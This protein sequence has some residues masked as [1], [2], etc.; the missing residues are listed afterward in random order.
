MAKH[1]ISA[2][3]LP[4]NVKKTASIDVWGRHG[5]ATLVGEADAF[6]LIGPVVKYSDSTLVRL[7]ERIKSL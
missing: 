4:K 1:R 3:S 6:H 2:P 5:S 7:I